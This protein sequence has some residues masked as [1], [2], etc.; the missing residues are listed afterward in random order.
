M[1]QTIVKIRASKERQQTPVKVEKANS[2]LEARRDQIEKV[3]SSKEY[4]AYTKQVPKHKRNS[5]DP[6]T[7]DKHEKMSSAEWNVRV[8]E[9][10]QK[11][12][13]TYGAPG[14][15]SEHST[16]KKSR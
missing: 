11:I 16:A 7:P 6:K 13:K 3:Y 14:T 2:A 15:S 10:Q 9:W 4:K 1:K 5:R 8:K 12:D